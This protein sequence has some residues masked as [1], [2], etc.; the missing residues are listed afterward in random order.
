MHPPQRTLHGGRASLP[1]RR[2]IRRRALRVRSERNLM[3][4]LIKSVSDFDG[5]A[6][7]IE[8]AEHVSEA[9]Q[10]INQ[11]DGGSAVIAD[12]DFPGTRGF[13]SLPVLM[14]VAPQLPIIILGDDADLFGQMNLVEH[15]AQDYVL[16][17]R[18]DA[19]TLVTVVHSAIARNAR[20]G[21]LFCDKERAQVTLN[22]TGDEV[23]QLQ[24]VAEGVENAEQ[25]RFL[26]AHDCAEGQ[27]YCFSESVDPGERQALS[28]VGKRRWAWQLSS[29]TLRVTN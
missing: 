16:R 23:F 2:T 19:K 18:L 5:D 28:S 29:P 27:R 3:N 6:L 8:T 20:E 11:I 1:T 24:A 7:T 25:L 13:E 17:R 14:G 15:G 12:C 9:T 4:G 22:S 10:R 26:Q 21:I